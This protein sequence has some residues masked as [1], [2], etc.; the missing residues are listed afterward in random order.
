MKLVSVACLLALLC[1]GMLITQAFARDRLQGEIYL[2]S[3]SEPVRDF[4]STTGF[5]AGLNIP[6]SRLWEV[7]LGGHEG[8]MFFRADISYYRWSERFSV[9][10]T[11]PKVALR[12]VPLFIAARYLHGL[13][14]RLGFF[15]EAGLEISFDET[16]IEWPGAASSDSE[17]NGGIAFGGGLEYSWAGD[18]FAGASL[19]LHALSDNFVSLAAFLGKRF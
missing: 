4:G 8:N 12:R 18:Y 2:S 13:T 9:R 3:G 19:R 17:V 7:D 11:R 6:F 14:D 5:G 15:G 10:R 16:T 1:S